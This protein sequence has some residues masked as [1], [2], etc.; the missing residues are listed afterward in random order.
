MSHPH[1]ARLPRLIGGAA[2]LALIGGSLVVTAAPA[3]A[4]EP[5]SVTYVARICD[6]Y[7]DVMANKA[8][9][10]IMESLRDLGADSTYAANGVVEPDAEAAGSPGCRPLTD[11]SLS[12]GRGIVGKSEAANYLSRA[13]GPY[14]G[15]PVTTTSSTARLDSA[16]APTGE[17]IEGAVTVPLTAD[18]I[19]AVQSGGRLVVQGGVGTDTLNGRQDDVAFAALRCAQDARNADNVDYVWFPNGAS[20][21]FCYYYA[22]T[23]PPGT[24]TITVR[25]EV[26]AETNGVGT[27]DFEG[28]LSFD[29]QDGEVGRF[30]LRAGAGAP[31][32]Q[33]FV[34]AAV[35]SGDEPWTVRE[36]DEAGWD[37]DGLECVSQTGDTEIAIDGPGA[38]I[39]LAAGD[40][41]VCT[42]TNHRR[43]TGAAALYKATLGRV[44]TFPFTVT[45]QRRTVE[46]TV[47]TTQEGAPVLVTATDSTEPG[48][49]TAREVMPPATGAGFWRM[50]TA[51][52]NGEAMPI[53]EISPGVWESSKVL[54]TGEGA[55]C[56]IVNE[57]VPTAS[58]ALA[59]ITTG[60]T[61][62]FAYDV[63]PL[64]EL[65][66]PDTGGGV[67]TT[68]ATTTRE[69][70]I[71]SA[72]A[73][74]E[75]IDVA[76]HS[77][78]GIQEV[79]P[80]ASDAGVW[81]L[82]SV[83]CGGAETS[84]H[85]ESAYVTVAVTEGAPA[86]VCTFTN[87]FV[88][89]GTLTVTKKAPSDPAVRPDDVRIVVDCGGQRTEIVLEAGSADV[90]RVISG[91][92]SPQT[93][94]LVEAATGAADG[95]DVAIRASLSRNGV[96]A[97][98]RDRLGAVT[99]EPGVDTVIEIENVYARN[100]G[101]SGEEPSG[102]QPSDAGITGT[103]S[104]A[105]S[106]HGLAA[107]GLDSTWAWPAA[108]G[109][110]LLA[111]GLM[112]VARRR[113]RA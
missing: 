62:T 65:G 3:S 66:E 13:S 45:S 15:G 17:V 81:R 51:Q 48:P 107:T 83:D 109:A 68:R 2:V 25:K 27:F 54:A 56:L 80:A 74:Y 6:D 7:T 32:T 22:V 39:R 5:L 33:T 38:E 28:S 71:A 47:T 111:A 112:L 108:G 21:V 23:P 24:G 69:G 40:D 19:A 70:E 37:F 29:K 78:F 98:T 84:V 93:C 31:G 103:E 113:R 106:A 57:Y 105:D 90:T 91:I 55:D 50:A 99:V 60:G 10:D 20:H 88:A 58:L 35:G 30:S 4:A 95:W 61:G 34:R 85:L 41:V 26:P 52:C 76:E 100:A 8:R 92:Q 63:F 49:I 110:V 97:E 42:Y 101:P 86:P 87:Q 64:N 43:P 82:Q 72:E 73:V 75:G 77:E 104:P 14:T 94:T 89:A 67:F 46:A 18:Q 44:G 59:K 96:L 53:S 1:P 79:M 11:W 36:L 12:L 16:G 9:N 102:E